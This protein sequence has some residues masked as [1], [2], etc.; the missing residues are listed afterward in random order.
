MQEG[1][2]VKFVSGNM[3][4]TEITRL[5]NKIMNYGCIFFLFIPFFKEF[6]CQ[7]D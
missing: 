2:Y 5:L 4:N 3:S 1:A 6:P 7:N